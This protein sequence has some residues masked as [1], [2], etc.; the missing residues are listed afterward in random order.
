[1]QKTSKHR[2]NEHKAEDCQEKELKT[3][4]DFSISCRK[5]WCLHN[6]VS[7]SPQRG[8]WIWRHS[9]VRCR[10]ARSIQSYPCTTKS[11]H[12]TEKKLIK[13]SLEPSQA[14]K[15][16]CTDNSMEFGKACEALSWNQST[17]T[18]HRSETIVIAERAVRRVK[19]RHFSSTATIR[20]GWNVVVRLHGILLPSAKCPRPLGRWE[21]AIRKTIWRTI[22]RAN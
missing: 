3:M 8:M 21:N 1:M 20:I 11:S 12:E 5:D 19:Q 13:N 14:P 15:V 7:Q 16:V 2:E 9:P 10:G 22:R 6:G 18:P 4:C 17:S